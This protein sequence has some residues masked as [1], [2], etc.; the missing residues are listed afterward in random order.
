MERCDNH[1]EI[2]STNV[3]AGGIAAVLDAG[4][5]LLSCTNRGTVNGTDGVGG[6]VGV[7]QNAN[8]SLTD[9]LNYAAVG[10]DGASIGAGGVVGR[11]GGALPAAPT[12]TWFPALAGTWAALRAWP[13]R[14]T[15]RG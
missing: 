5:S 12:T 10:A 15:P 13:R 8:S 11:I 3:N 2:R 6:V 14:R 4:S 9:C 1:A 7:V